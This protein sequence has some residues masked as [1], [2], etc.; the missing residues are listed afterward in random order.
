MPGVLWDSLHQ[1]SRVTKMIGGGSGENCLG[2]TLVIL[3]KGILDLASVAI[4]NFNTF[5]KSGQG[6]QWERSEHNHLWILGSPTEVLTCPPDETSSSFRQEI[7]KKTG[8]NR[9][10]RKKVLRKKKSKTSLFLKFLDAL[11]LIEQYTI[12][13]HQGNSNMIKYEHVCFVKLVRLRD[14]NERE[15][16]IK[17]EQLLVSSQTNV[18]L[19]PMLIPT[20][21]ACPPINRG[22]PFIK[23][24]HQWKIELV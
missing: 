16:N 3:N 13:S 6:W 9:I 7:M 2:N 15:R 11:H 14:A 17:Y 21:H 4:Y 22:H 8:N 24:H 10:E 12:P 19:V 18:W 20:V 5:Q 23:Y 1:R